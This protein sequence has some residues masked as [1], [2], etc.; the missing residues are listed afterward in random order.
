MSCHENDKIIE[1][2]YEKAE[3]EGFSLLLQE[4]S[5]CFDLESAYH[6][7]TTGELQ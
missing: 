5:I 7:L 4:G 3:E 2:A 6:Y 1:A